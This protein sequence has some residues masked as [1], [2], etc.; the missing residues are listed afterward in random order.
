VCVLA[1]GDRAGIF[2]HGTSGEGC[3]AETLALPGRQR[4]LAEA[5]LATGTP[6]VVVLLTGRPYALGGIA[7]RAAAVVQGF[8]PGE[9]GGTAVAGILSGRLEPSGRLP[10]SV[11]R[12]PGGQPG[13]YLRARA[14]ASSSWS[15]VDPEPLFAFGHGLTWTRFGYEDLEVDASAPTDG[16]VGVVVTVRNLGER[17]GTEV[18]QLYLSDPVASV[19]RPVRWLAG[20][21]RVRLEPGGAARVSFAVHADRTSFTGLDLQRIVEPGTIEVAVGSSSQELPLT[22]SFTLTGPERVL[23]PGRVLT[24]PVTVTAT[25]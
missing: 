18:V 19:V 3:D 6:T 10:V 9:E 11:P 13:T 24:V 4:E 8:F 17:A 21:A 1:L 12:G 7:D 2:G 15:A 20:W 14:G 25:R 23:G 22:G 5:V 16:E